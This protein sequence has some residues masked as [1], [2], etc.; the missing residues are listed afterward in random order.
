MKS[1]GL[2]LSELST[3]E[4]Q[5]GGDWKKVI[6]KALQNNIDLFI[7][8]KKDLSVSY[9]KL[10]YDESYDGTPLVIPPKKESSFN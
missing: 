10:D 6:K 7:C 3:V 5:L 2:N 8:L 9:E 1:C 4:F